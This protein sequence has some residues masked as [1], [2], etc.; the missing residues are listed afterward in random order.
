MLM[1]IEVLV[2]MQLVSDAELLHVVRGRGPRE[3]AVV[4]VGCSGRPRVTEVMLVTGPSWA[5]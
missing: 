4:I 1:L 3:G 2:L 5:C